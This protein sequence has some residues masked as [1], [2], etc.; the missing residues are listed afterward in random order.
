MDA[1][2]VGPTDAPNTAACRRAILVLVFITY[3]LLW[4]IANWPALRQAWWY[5]DDFIIGEQISSSAAPV[6]LKHVL[7]HGRP[8]EGVWFLT[9][10]LDGSSDQGIQN[11]LLRFVQGGLHALVGVLAADLLWRQTRRWTAFL[12]ALPFILWPFNGEATLWRAAG[13][14]PLAA[15]LGLLGVQAI[16]RSSEQ[17]NLSCIIGPSLIVLGVL[18]NQSAAFAGAVVWVFVVGLIV[19]GEG[20]IR[21]SRV[22]RE[23]IMLVMGY[24]IGGVASF[25]IVWL[26]G[27]PQLASNILG[28]L[29]YLL[30]LNR[31]FITWP[32]F[33]PPWL[34][35]AHILLLS[36][37]S[38]VLVRAL[39]EKTWTVRQALLAIT[40]VMTGLVT[41][42]AAIVLVA[43][44]WPA[45]RVMYLAPFLITGAATILAQALATWKVGRTVSLVLVSVILAG[46]VKMAWINS[47]EYV[48]VFKEDLHL[49]RQLENYAA[50]EH[51]QDG[52]IYVATSP[53]VQIRK[54][55][56]YGLEYVHGDSKIP[57]FFRSWSAHPFVRRF[58]WLRPTEDTAI[59]AQCLDRCFLTM[60]KT[61]FRFYKLD[62]TN[63]I[64]VCP[65]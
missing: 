57:A 65:P 39:R 55:N 43:R 23:A 44:T 29:V 13:Q 47:S 41:P 63:A 15:L 27:H 34:S 18:T 2:L 28:K 56:P 36:M 58:S 14:Y 7:G 11:R 19:L 45:W 22:R 54:W 48:K 25:L 52:A 9:F 46:Y 35:A 30:H 20:Q 37:L 16:R 6:L 1:P 10:L 64:C 21:M 42:Y 4:S 12:S 59:R 40:F 60:D 62:A 5:C 61:G 26:V 8:G 49:L 24:C 17:P 51:I 32:E 38:L 33:Y 3:L 31:L 50:Q 53:E